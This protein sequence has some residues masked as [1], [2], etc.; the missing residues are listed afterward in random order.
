MSMLLFLLL[1][2]LLVLSDFSP[3]KDLFVVQGQVVN[4]TRIETKG[5]L[6]GFRFCVGN[7]L[8]TFTYS[9][10]DPNVAHAWSALE[11]SKVIR[12]QYA[13]HR[14]QN[15]TLWG[16]AVDGKSIASTSELE[17]ARV[18]RFALLLAGACVSGAVAIW[19]F[20]SWL[21]SRRLRRAAQP[22]AAADGFAAH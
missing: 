18:T 8:K 20:K 3:P 4:L 12:V 9:D 6:T 13:A 7:P 21:R 10:P 5:K 22:I 14:Y 19:S 11:E 2:A 15:P 16:L 1:S 17:A